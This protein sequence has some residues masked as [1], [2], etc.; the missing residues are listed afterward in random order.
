[1][2]PSDKRAFFII[3]RSPAP[4]Q[5]LLLM[6]DSAFFNKKMQGRRGLKLA[7]ERFD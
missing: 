4:L 2:K 6:A 3:K 7:T 5:I 1:M